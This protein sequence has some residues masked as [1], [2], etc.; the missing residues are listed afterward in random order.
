ME[1]EEEGEGEAATPKSERVSEVPKRVKAF[2]WFN[3]G[4]PTSGWSI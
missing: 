3:G 2:I 4:K 1:M